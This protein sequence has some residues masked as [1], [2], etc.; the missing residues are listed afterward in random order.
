[1][2]TQQACLTL[3]VPKAFEEKLADILLANPVAASAG[4]TIRDINAYGANITYRT[5]MERVHGRVQGVEVVVIVQETEASAVL[6]EIKQAM[7]GRGVVYR[8]NTISDAGE[9]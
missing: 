7:P 1:M 3:L 5:A 2:T 4:F 8:L 6:D 9:I